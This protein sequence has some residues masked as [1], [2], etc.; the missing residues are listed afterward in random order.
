MSIVADIVAIGSMI[1][2]A[3]FSVWMLKQLLA[4]K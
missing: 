4:D 3:G 1:F 2:L